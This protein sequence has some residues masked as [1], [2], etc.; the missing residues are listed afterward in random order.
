MKSCDKCI[1]MIEYVMV[2]NQ[3]HKIQTCSGDGW[4]EHEGIHYIPEIT[5]FDESDCL[6]FKEK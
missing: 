6:M 3:D 1:H 2:K 5:E 4:E